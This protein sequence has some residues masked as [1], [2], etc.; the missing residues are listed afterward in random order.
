MTTGHADL[1]QIQALLE[2]TTV[3]ATRKD[4]NCSSASWSS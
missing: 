4:T 1:V 3:V 2:P